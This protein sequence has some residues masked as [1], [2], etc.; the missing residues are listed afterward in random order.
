MDAPTSQSAP[1]TVVPPAIASGAASSEF[2]LTKVI[3][4]AGGVLTVL[5]GTLSQIAPLL[6]SGTQVGQYIAG[7]L[8]VVS[9]ILTVVKAMGYT[10]SRTQV[11]VAQA[12]AQGAGP[13]AQ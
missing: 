13:I 6:P 2:Q 1:A 9:M 12:A 3:T 5:F 11:K 4:V 10:N 7:A 8:S